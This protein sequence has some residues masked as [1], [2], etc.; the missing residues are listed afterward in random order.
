MR[1]AGNGR[2]RPASGLAEED[3][4]EGKQQ[5]LHGRMIRD[6]V[7]PFPPT[8][9]SEHPESTM[10]SFTRAAVTHPTAQAP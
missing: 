5:R 10:I 1:N 6:K 8:V 4:K 3:G 9:T 2:P 7:N